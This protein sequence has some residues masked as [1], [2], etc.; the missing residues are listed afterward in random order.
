MSFCDGAAV[1]YGGRPPGDSTEATAMN[2]L[3][4]KR[5]GALDDFLQN[6]EF[7]GKKW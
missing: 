2:W 6:H 5:L 1:V 4:S 7:L 3:P